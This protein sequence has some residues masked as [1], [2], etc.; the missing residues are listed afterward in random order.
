MRDPQFFAQLEKDAKGLL[1]ELREGWTA[2][3]IASV[4]ADIEYGEWDLAIEQI[5]GAIVRLN[6]PLTAKVLAKL[7]DLARRMNLKG[8]ESVRALHDYAG[9]LGLE[10]VVRAR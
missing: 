1:N 7:D 10:K 8:S 2:D 4:R 6:K 5:A 3:E 9:R